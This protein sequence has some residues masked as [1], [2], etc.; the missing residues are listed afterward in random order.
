MESEASLRV[1]KSLPPV[2]SWARSI[3]YTPPDFATLSN[4]SVVLVRERTVPT[5]R[6]LI[7]GEVIANFCG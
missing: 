7:V 6:S 1:H 5:E 4:N 2:P 3:Q